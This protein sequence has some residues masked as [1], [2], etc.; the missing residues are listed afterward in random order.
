MTTRSNVYE[1]VVG[2][3]ESPIEDTLIDDGGVSDISGFQKVEFHL[4][5]PDD[6][7]VTATDSDAAV[8]VEDSVNG[9]V[10]YEFQSGDLDQDGRYRYEWEV[11]FGDGGI[12]TYPSSGWEPIFVR[13]ELA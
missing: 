13:D 3:T 10:K 2:D 1:R 9:Q 8:T 6:T 12:L 5:K 11:T 7:S 4:I